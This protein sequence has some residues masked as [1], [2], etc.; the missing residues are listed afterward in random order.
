VRLAAIVIILCLMGPPAFA[1]QEPL[2]RECHR[3]VSQIARYKG[4]VKLAQE[5]GNELWENATKQQIERLTE[6]RDDRC[7]EYAE[8]EAAAAVAA[9]WRRFGQMLGTAAK[10]AA[11]YFTMGGF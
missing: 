10:L 8:R 2:R 7:P 5:R 6:R 3:L 9:A 11:K 1:R 4:D